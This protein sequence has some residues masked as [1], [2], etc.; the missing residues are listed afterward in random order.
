VRCSGHPPPTPRRARPCCTLRPRADGGG[1][2]CAVCGRR[3]RTRPSCTRRSLPPSPAT[4]PAGGATP[5]SFPLCSI[6]A[7]K[8]GA[9]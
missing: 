5:R 8:P 2:R 4:R 6:G 1:R 7:E 3:W 9:V